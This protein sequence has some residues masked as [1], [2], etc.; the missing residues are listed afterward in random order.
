VKRNWSDDELAEQW[1]LNV[2]ELTFRPPDLRDY[3]LT[4]VFVK[5][6]LGAMDFR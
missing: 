4:S 3:V 6:R 5:A 1:S 2:E